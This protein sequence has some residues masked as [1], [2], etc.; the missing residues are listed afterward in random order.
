MKPK[1][2]VQDAHFFGEQYT[3]YFAIVEPGE[4]KYIY[5]L[6][7]DTMHDPKFVNEVLEYLQKMQ[8]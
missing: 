1:F 2:E 7:D 3:F 8:H 5:H 6:I 4:Q